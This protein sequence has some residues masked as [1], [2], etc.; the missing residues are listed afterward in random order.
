METYL[1]LRG[2]GEVRV[3]KRRRVTDDGNQLLYVETEDGQ[4]HYVAVPLDV[5]RRQKVLKRRSGVC[6]PVATSS[7]R[8][9]ML[10]VRT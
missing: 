7:I 5:Y 4:R 9:P 2:L 10:L 8:S 6:A 3:L 1:R